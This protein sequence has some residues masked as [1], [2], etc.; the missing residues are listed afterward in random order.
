MN[1][2]ARLSH[3]KTD[4]AGVGSTTTLDDVLVRAVEQASREYDREAQRQFYAR[5]VTRY[6]TG[7]PR[8]R[9][10]LWLPFDAASTTSLLLDADGDG[11]YEITLVVDTDYFAYREGEDA[12]A[13]ICR[14]EINPNG[15]QIS[16]WPTAP[17]AL[18]WTG[19]EGY[20]YELESSTLTTNEELD[21]SETDVTVSASAASLIYPGDTIVVESEQMEVAAVSTTTLTV[22][23]GINGTTAATH[24]TAKTVY[25]RRYPR[26][27]ERAVAERVVGL[28][29]DS[30]GGY[31][32]GVTLTGDMVGAAGTTQV[33]GQYARWGATVRRYKR[34]SLVGV[35]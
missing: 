29:W 4:I 22:V 13:P 7:S 18:K 20:S 35:A 14:L 26:D 12:N 9:F 8:D 5:Q 33:R 1:N 16:C 11:A 21:A 24:T 23:R 28:R 25:V 27:V 3:V 19:L 15:D 32:G 2:Y 31:D 17:R 30:Q 10:N 6:F 34:Y